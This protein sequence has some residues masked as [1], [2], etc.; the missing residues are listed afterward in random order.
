[1][2]YFNNLIMTQS[3]IGKMQ[4]ISNVVPDKATRALQRSMLAASLNTGR[5]TT[6]QELQDRFQKL[7]D[8]AL[9]NGFIPNVEMLALASRL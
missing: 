8:F 9:Q 3:S 1:M 5:C 4:D 7:F 2:Q 6:S